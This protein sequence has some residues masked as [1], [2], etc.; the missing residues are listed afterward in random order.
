VG[1]YPEMD[2]LFINNLRELIIEL[3]A[4]DVVMVVSS[5]NNRV[6]IKHKQR[7]ITRIY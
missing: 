7:Y 3:L 6:R 5:G 1:E 2:P 4:E